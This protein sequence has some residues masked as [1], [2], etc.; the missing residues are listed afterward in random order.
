MVTE[1][2]KPQ[3]TQVAECERLHDVI[4]YAG[5]ISF[6]FAREAVKG[7]FSS[8]DLVQKYLLRNGGNLAIHVNRRQCYC[9][10]VLIDRLDRKLT[11]AEDCLTSEELVLC[12]LSLYDLDILK[13]YHAEKC[14]YCQEE[15]E[16]IKALIPERM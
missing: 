5:S 8:R 12:A 6:A 16:A 7:G 14:R 9:L 4:E 1:Q 13:R 2:V 10:A 3:E 15:V 11:R